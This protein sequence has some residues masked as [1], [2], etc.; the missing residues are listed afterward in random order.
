MTAIPRQPRRKTT[1]AAKDQDAAEPP[2]PAQQSQACSFCESPLADVRW[3]VVG[4]TAV[5][6]CDECL[7]RAAYTIG[8]HGCKTCTS[9]PA[10]G[11][12]G[13]AV[14]IKAEIEPEPE[15]VPPPRVLITDRS[16]AASLRIVRDTQDYLREVYREI[17]Q[18]I[19]LVASGHEVGRCWEPVGRMIAR[20]EVGHLIRHLNTLAETIEAS[21]EEPRP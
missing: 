12:P 10:G 17:E 7:D 15:P 8:R 11:W 13:R 16:R 3:L 2:V 5:A 14:P 19:G 1:K 21:N 9:A 20:G 18:A 4:A 6:I